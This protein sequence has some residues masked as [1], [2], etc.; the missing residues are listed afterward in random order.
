MR[1]RHDRLGEVSVPRR[2]WRFVPVVPLLAACNPGSSASGR[3]ADTAGSSSET[4][5]AVPF[6]LH[7][8][9]RFEEPFA[10]AFLPDGTAL[11]TEKVGHLKLWRQSKTIDVAGVPAVA[12]VSQGGLLDIAPAPDFART[13]YVY[14]SYSERRPAGSALALARATLESGASPRLAGLE[15]IWRSGSD[16][17]GGQFGATIAFAPDGKSLFLSSGERQRFAPAQDPDQAIGKI[18][19][20]TLDGRPSPDNPGA[21]R[22]G[23]ASISVIDP[24]PDTEAARSA[25]GR[26][27]RLAGPNLA[28]AE[29]W[30][31]GH[32]NPYGLAFASDGRLWEHEMGPRGGDEVNLILPAKN[33]GWPVVSNGSNYDG[34][35]IPTHSTRPEF[36]TPK[37]WWNPS[38]SPA[39]MIYYSGDVFPQWKGSLLIGALSGESLI[40][41]A[42]DGDRAS[43]VNQWKI[44]MRIRDVAQAPDGNVWLLGDDG[45]LMQLAPKR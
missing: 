18:V 35:P 27:V 39:G 14:L 44:G 11:I 31:S 42:I 33:Y 12:N 36:E 6:N 15:V 37:I 5:T 2:A 32:R 24:P 16:G 17:A 26:T 23:A 8:I 20:L 41:I 34:K 43:E 45:W 21:G 40:R 7:Q 1:D 3:D 38:I 9:A 19:H 10:L 22:T 28:P 25:R 13:H 4:S 29:T 30:S